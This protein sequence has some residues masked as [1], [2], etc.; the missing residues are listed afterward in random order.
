MLAAPDKNSHIDAL[1]AL[2]ELFSSEDDMA[3]LHQA[4][5]LEEIKI[6]VDRF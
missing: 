5:T 2:A 1:S 4:N 6:I 3:K